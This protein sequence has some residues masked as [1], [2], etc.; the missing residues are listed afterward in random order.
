MNKYTYVEYGNNLLISQKTE[1]YS[2]NS[3]KNK[4]TQD[5]DLASYLLIKIL[6]LTRFL[7]GNEKLLVCKMSALRIS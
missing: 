4:H 7:R 1:N 3:A 5:T 6:H 2:L